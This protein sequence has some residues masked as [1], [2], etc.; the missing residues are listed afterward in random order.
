[1]RV[2]ILRC[3]KKYFI[4]FPFYLIIYGSA[5]AEVSESQQ[6]NFLEFSYGATHRGEVKSDNFSAFGSRDLSAVIQY[7]ASKFS[8]I[9]YGIKKLGW[10]LLDISLSAN[11]INTSVSSI[12]IPA[13]S[14]YSNLNNKSIVD[15]YLI[16][17]RYSMAASES[18]SL[19][20]GVGVGVAKYA[21]VGIQGMSGSL[22]FGG[23]F[24]FNRNMYAVIKYKVISV[25]E[26]KFNN[27]AIGDS[28]KI[29]RQIIPAFDLG[30]GFVF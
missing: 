30:I 21:D 25:P 26:S 2:N 10:G 23:Q 27:A 8:G 18:L 13:V 28:I 17:A 5:F 4:V 29:S 9:E 7:D 19:I 1:M 3:A 11:Q 24:D 12:S 14:Y 20:Y 16:N 6:K 15:L 22:T